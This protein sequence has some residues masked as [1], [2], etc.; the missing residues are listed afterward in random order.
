MF[1]RP[2]RHAQEVATIH[3]DARVENRAPKEYRNCSE[4]T[5][6]D[7]QLSLSGDRSELQ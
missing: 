1:I 5:Y 4:D 3:G 2:K 7:D 6:F